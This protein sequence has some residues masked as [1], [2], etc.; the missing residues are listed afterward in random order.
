MRSSKSSSVVFM[1]A[2]SGTS[3]P[4][5]QNILLPTRKHRSSSHFTSSVTA[6][7]F[8]QKFLRVSR[9]M[10]RK[11][12][13]STRGGNRTRTNFAVHRI[14][15]PVRLPIPPPEQNTQ[16]F[17]RCCCFIVVERCFSIF[18]CVSISRCVNDIFPPLLPFVF[19]TGTSFISL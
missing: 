13:G 5:M 9:S 15:S 19:T 11:N 16:R 10:R 18:F 17:L 1:D 12:F 8:L 14:L 2:L 3:N 4:V 7:S 6:G